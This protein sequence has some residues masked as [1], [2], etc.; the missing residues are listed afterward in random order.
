MGIVSA[1]SPSMG[2]RQY[3]RPARSVPSHRRYPNGLTGTWSLL[4]AAHLAHS[5]IQKKNKTVLF[6]VESQRPQWH[7]SDIVF[8]S[9]TTLCVCYLFSIVFFFIWLPVGRCSG[10]VWLEITSSMP[11]GCRWRRIGPTKVGLKYRWK[12]WRN[13][14]QSD[15]MSDSVVFN[16]NV[17]KCYLIFI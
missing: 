2:C 6:T 3:F 16:I 8:I 4:C 7:V 12:Q 1:T 9:I 5:Q 17:L 14:H 15:G 13:V 10:C 11:V